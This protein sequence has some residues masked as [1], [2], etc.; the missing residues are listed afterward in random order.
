MNTET[1]YIAMGV[2]DDPCF[3]CLLYKNCNIMCPRVVE[4]YKAR[5]VFVP[6]KEVYDDKIGM[7]RW[8]PIEEKKEETNYIIP[9]VEKE[10]FKYGKLVMSIIGIILFISC[11]Y[12][13]L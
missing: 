3:G 2:E 4:Y 11:L 6:G 1:N 8:Q 5:L 10:N 12:F 7:V 9:V 13:N